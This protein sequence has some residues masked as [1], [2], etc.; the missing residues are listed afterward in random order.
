M[1]HKALFKVVLCNS[2]ASVSFCFLALFL[3]SA[4]ALGQEDLL[5]ERWLV[6]E[7]AHFTLYSQLSSRQTSALVSELELWR[8]AAAMII[9]DGEPFPLANVPNYIYAFSDVEDIQHFTAG[10]ETAF[11]ASTPRANFMAFVAGNDESRKYALH[12][13]AHFLQKNFYDLRVPRWYEEG[14]AG[15]LSRLTINRGNAELERVS[16]QTHELMA[17][18]N[19]ELSME[20]FL[21]RDEALASPRLIQIANLKSESLLQYLLHGYQ[22]VEF[23]DRRAALA[24]YLGFLFAG[25]NQ[26]FAFDQSFGVTTRQ[27]DEE[28]ELYL[29]ESRRPRGEI[30][31]APLQ[32]LAQIEP[33]QVE[34]PALTLMLGEL[35]LNSGGIKKAEVFFNKL[36]E[37]DQPVARAYSGL[38]DAIRFQSLPGRD[39]EIANYFELALEIAPDSPDILLDYGEYW[40]SE[41][42]DCEKVY[43]QA[44][45]QQLMEDI[46]QKFLKSLDLR[47]NS[48]ESHLAL[49]EFYLLEGQDW[50]LGKPYQQRAFEL[51]P[52]DGFIME[53]SVKYAIAAEEFGEA[54]RLLAE[55]SQPIHFFGEPSYVSD[56]REQLMRKR[57]GEVFDACAR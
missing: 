57:R 15:Y 53:A 28:F 46:K 21:Y 18:I 20:R 39:Q 52:A 16:A 44:Q 40:E 17:A 10:E 35:A 26:R 30:T 23:T 11:F 50:Q 31:L 1:I 19:D 41:L 47:E 45:R 29:N 36:I 2:L 56:M 25:R 55:M 32:E 22:E 42:Q 37:S 14:M 5:D 13:Y 51:L 27:L 24:D 6:T 8:Q 48:A 43:P 12:R 38:G 4:S 9:R 33:T 34:R 7:S 54:E 3:P 49:A